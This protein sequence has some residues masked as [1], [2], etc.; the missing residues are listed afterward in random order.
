MAKIELSEE[1]MD[2]LNEKIS[3]LNEICSEAAHS[4]HIGSEIILPTATI[5]YFLPDKEINRHSKKSGGAY[6]SYTGQVRRVDMTL[7]TMTFQGK[8]GKHKTVAITDIS[9]IQGDFSE[10]Q[11]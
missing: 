10:R 1:Q 4:R 5:T 11:T 9:D 7:G 8:N 2:E 6:V 3:L